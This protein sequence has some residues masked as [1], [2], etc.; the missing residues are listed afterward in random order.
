MTKLRTK[1]LIDFNLSAM[2]MKIIFCDAKGICV[3]NS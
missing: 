2:H 3:S 1:F